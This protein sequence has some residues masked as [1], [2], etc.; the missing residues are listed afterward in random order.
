MIFLKSREF[1]PVMVRGRYD[2]GWRMR[3]VYVADLED[4]QSQGMQAASK[5]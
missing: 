1:F 4:G 2:Y 5:A 3:E